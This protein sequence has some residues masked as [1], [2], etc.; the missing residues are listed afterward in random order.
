MSTVVPSEVQLILTFA[1]KVLVAA[2][3]ATAFK[4]FSFSLDPN[5]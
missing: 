5:E 1:V 4:K 3:F 2:L